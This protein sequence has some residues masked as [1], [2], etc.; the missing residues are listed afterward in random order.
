MTRPAASWI[1]DQLRKMEREKTHHLERF[2][3][4][5]PDHWH[6]MYQDDIRALHWASVGYDK[7]AEREAERAGE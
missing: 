6:Q 3:K 5:R 1:R 2:G 4:D 7:L